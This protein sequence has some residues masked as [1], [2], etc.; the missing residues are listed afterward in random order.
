M[1]KRFDFFLLISLVCSCNTLMWASPRH[2][3]QMEILYPVVFQEENSE[4]N[5]AEAINEDKNKDEVVAEE[6]KQ[7]EKKEDDVASEVDTQ[8]GTNETKN[9]EAENGE[10][11]ENIEERDVEKTKQMINGERAFD[12]SAPMFPSKK[13]IEAQNVQEV[14]SILAVLDILKELDDANSIFMLKTDEIVSKDSGSDLNTVS[15]EISEGDA[16]LVAQVSDESV[17]EG[18][19]EKYEEVAEDNEDDFI[20]DDFINDEEKKDEQTE[21]ILN[22]E[23]IVAQD[24]EHFLTF[25][26]E[27]EIENDKVDLLPKQESLNEKG[28]LSS[29]VEEDDKI[30]ISRYTDVKKGQRIDFSYP[31][32]GWV[33]LG[34]ENSKRGLNYTKR[35]MED[36]KTFF[37]FKAEEEGNYIL[38]FSYFDAFSGDFIVDAVSVKVLTNKE[39]SSPDSLVFD[40]Q[41]GA[42]KKGEETNK[43]EVTNTDISKSYSNDEAT[44]QEVISTTTDKKVPQDVLIDSDKVGMNVQDESKKSDK[45]SAS[46]KEVSPTD[47][48]TTEATHTKKEEKKE[49]TVSEKE[50]R[51][52]KR[53]R[54]TKS[55][56]TKKEKERAPSSKREEIV[57]PYQE[58]EV[59]ANVAT[60]S[61]TNAGKTVGN[62]KIAKEIIAQA[63]EAIAKGDADAALHSLEN[64]FAIASDEIDRAYFLQGKAYELN[65]KRKN[66]KLALQAY[67]FLTTTFP[68]SEYRAIANERIR[69]IEKF[70]VNIK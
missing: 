21:P 10:I 43:A 54:E 2:A 51:A 39:G 52:N 20:I 23:Y 25:D 5:G 53:K 60:L 61:V 7:E 14:P 70:F 57:N 68:N 27:Q 17:N 32:E 15:A 36:G 48:T 42:T 9:K 55:F 28:Q 31:G 69:Y 66:I 1:I 63:D 40:Y 64:F 13:E 16:G 4:E 22:G 24:D 26:E 18:Q 62:D 47:K 34:E 50:E 6:K 56:P 30:N 49:K 44:A 37:S 67:K 59:K 8:A 19:N 29:I 11:K 35:K 12:V 65:G 3:L 45:D 46:E 58:P 33:Y 41:K 38:N